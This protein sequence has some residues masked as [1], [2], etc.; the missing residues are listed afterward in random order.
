[1]IIESVPH[2]CAYLPTSDTGLN[3]LREFA[4]SSAIDAYQSIRRPGNHSIGRMQAAQ[5]VDKTNVPILLLAKAAS[6]QFAFHW[7]SYQTL[8]FQIQSFCPQIRLDNEIQL[9]QGDGRRGLHP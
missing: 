7:S 6:Q 9:L 3:E 2:I 5:S 1:M 8:L 4:S